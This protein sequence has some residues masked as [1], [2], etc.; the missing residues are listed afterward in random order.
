MLTMLTLG[1]A[2]AAQTPARPPKP[3]NRHFWHTETTTASPQAIWEVWTKVDA[4][5]LFDSELES[6][7]INTPNGRLSTPGQT[8]AVVDLSGRTSRFVITE[9]TPE[10]SYTYVAQL[11]ACKLYV[12]HLIVELGDGRRSITHEVWFAGLM[13]GPFAALLGPRFRRALPGVVQAVDTLATSLDQSS[14]H[15][16]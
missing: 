2:L 5:H 10:L 7:Q 11:P 16:Q 6:A 14:P 15:D 1:L 8:G 12:R 13:R 9:V 4:W 3:K